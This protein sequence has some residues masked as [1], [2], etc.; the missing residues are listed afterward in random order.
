MDN[1]M[2]H[3]VPSIQE[4]LKSR[5]AEDKDAEDFTMLALGFLLLDAR[6]GA[7]GLIDDLAAWLAGI[8]K[9]KWVTELKR[10]KK[11]GEIAE[12]L[13]QNPPSNSRFDAEKAMEVINIVLDSI[14]DC[15]QI[16]IWRFLDGFGLTDIAS[17]VGLVALGAVAKRI[18]DCL[19][20]AREAGDDLDFEFT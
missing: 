1:L 4:M 6:K 2:E 7:A 5:G 3:D 15:K 14:G 16:L 13:I 12:E 19:R 9:N 18:E 20:Q 10:R 11:F 8:A 17:R